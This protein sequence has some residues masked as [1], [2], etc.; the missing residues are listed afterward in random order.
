[1]YKVYKLINT[2]ISFFYYLRDISINAI[3]QKATI[4]KTL[5]ENIVIL[6]IIRLIIKPIMQI[7]TKT[8]QIFSIKFPM[9][10]FY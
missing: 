3:A 2:L 9:S 4:N 7:T 8:K 5:K 1:M 10:F 6:L